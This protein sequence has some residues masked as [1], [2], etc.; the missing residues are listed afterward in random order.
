MHYGAFANRKDAAIKLAK[1]IAPSP[2]ISTDTLILGLVRGGAVIASELAKRLS[3]GWDVYTVRKIGAPSQPEFAVGAICEQGTYVFNHDVLNYFGLG[4]DWQ[5]EAVADAKGACDVLQNALRGGAPLVGLADRDVILCDDGMATGLTMQVAIEG[6]RS[7]GVK[8]VAVAVPVLSS[9]AL[10]LLD[11]MH[12]H[13]YYLGC[14]DDFRAVG[15]YYQDF[16]AVDT[17]E[18]I[19]LLA[20]R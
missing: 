2:D 1:V 5:S 15:L 4:S 13:P 8:S 12:V 11:S 18:V 14:P 19:R 17:L 20:A 3:L 10:D 9:D 7:Q 6:V 16:S